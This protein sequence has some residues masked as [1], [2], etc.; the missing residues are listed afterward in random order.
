MRNNSL[1]LSILQRLIEQCMGIVETA[2][3]ILQNS[4]LSS[5]LTAS[6]VNSVILTTRLISDILTTTA[7]YS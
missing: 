7:L 3:L 6:Q 4:L 5:G 2:E 1:Q